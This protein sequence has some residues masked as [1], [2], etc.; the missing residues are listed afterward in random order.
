MGITG[1]REKA[2]LKNVGGGAMGLADGL[3][4]VPEG[5]EGGRSSP[6]CS[7]LMVAD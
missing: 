1:S 7:T 3:D 5:K 2:D 6:P 4:V